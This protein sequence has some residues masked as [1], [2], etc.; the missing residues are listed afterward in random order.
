[1][2]TETRAR[3]SFEEMVDR[4]KC[5]RVN[6]LRSTINSAVT[7][8]WPDKSVFRRVVQK[9]AHS[10]LTGGGEKQE[11]YCAWGAPP[12]ELEKQDQGLW[13]EDKGHRRVL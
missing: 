12:T 8:P 3:E 7:G 9:P 6:M 13:S 5:C 4:V 1:M 10:R 11:G 2:L